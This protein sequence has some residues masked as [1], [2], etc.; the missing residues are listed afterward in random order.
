MHV[1]DRIDMDEKADAR[2]H[3]DHDRRKGIEQKLGGGDEIARSY[4]GKQSLN[5]MPFLGR[6]L[7]K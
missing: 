5:N 2:N 6:P 4:P 1:S 3:E 7:S